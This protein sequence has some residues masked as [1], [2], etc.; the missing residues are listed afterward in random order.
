MA[1]LHAATL[2]LFGALG[3]ST[4]FH[5]PVNIHARVSER[6]GLPVNDTRPSDYYMSGVVPGPRRLPGVFA[7]RLFNT[8]YRE[9]AG[10]QHAR[11]G[12]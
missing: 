5:T 7:D 9:V 10:I 2:T 8:A 3:N 1:P 4:E 6:L 12:G 11:S